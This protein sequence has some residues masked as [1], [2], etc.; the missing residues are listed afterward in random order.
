MEER[1][2]GGE[3]ADVERAGGEEGGAEE[4]STVIVVLMRHCEMWRRNE[5]E[6]E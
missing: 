4:A 2:S 5:G 6:E 3:V 1:W